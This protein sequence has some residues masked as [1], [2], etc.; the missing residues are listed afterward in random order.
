MKFRLDLKELFILLFVYL[1]T[2]FPGAVNAQNVGP[3]FN[4]AFQIAQFTLVYFFYKEFESEKINVNIDKRIIGGFLIS[5]ALIVITSWDEVTRS[6]NSDEI[7]YAR[8]INQHALIGLEKINF[9]GEPKFKMLAITFVIA[10][11]F[12]LTFRFCYRESRYFIYFLSLCLILKI[13]SSSLFSFSLLHQIG[14]GLITSASQLLFF[15]ENISYRIEKIIIYILGVSFLVSTYSQK[16][17]YKAV[18]LIAMSVLAFHHP[19]VK[20]SVLIN[21][22][23]VFTFLIICVILASGKLRLGI[24]NLL[25]IVL[26]GFCLRLNCIFILPIILAKVLWEKQPITYK[27]FL[28]CIAVVIPRFLEIY[29]LTNVK[30]GSGFI[31]N[32]E[33]SITCLYNNLGYFGILTS[34]FALGFLCQNKKYYLIAI[35]FIFAGITFSLSDKLIIAPRYIFEFSM[36]F[37]IIGVIV[38]CTLNIKHVAA[39][40]IIAVGLIFFGHYETKGHKKD[41]PI[42]TSEYLQNRK[43]YLQQWYV[44]R[45]PYVYDEPINN[46]EKIPLIVGFDYGAFSLVLNNKPFE[47]YLKTKDHYNDIIQKYAKKDSKELLIYLK[48][49]KNYSIII[50]EI[51][52]QKLA[53]DLKREGWLKK[54][55]FVSKSWRTKTY[56][57]EYD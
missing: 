15:G 47:E 55:V 6:L 33:T 52:G 5:I 35:P 8:L 4:L 31:A 48:D 25:L 16:E 32:F 26:C 43:N 37:V 1:L 11:L 40:Y 27:Y 49:K 7:F 22:A 30:G 29:F 39:N 34:I 20:Y 44:T 38:L 41:M 10:I 57:L 54:K 50:A 42:F 51:G 56:L 24:N 17:N 18:L 21:E 53:E 3:I 45:N 12:F 36:P 14:W 13:V 46:A 23:S 2:L 9:I 19:L 28:L